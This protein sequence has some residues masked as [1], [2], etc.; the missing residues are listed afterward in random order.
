MARAVASCS[1]E[2]SR[3]HK[4]GAAGG[5]GGG[6]CSG[7]R[8]RAAFKDIREFTDADVV[9]DYR[10]LEEALLEKERAKRWRPQYGVGSGAAARSDRPPAAAKVIALLTQQAKARGVELFCMP[11][12]MARRVSKCSAP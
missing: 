6:G 9:S 2:C 12:G 1:L 8:D 11:D 4:A 10:F 7:K 3:A 5:G